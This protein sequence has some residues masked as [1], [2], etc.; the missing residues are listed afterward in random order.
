[1]QMHTD[2]QITT[3]EA[4]RILRVDTSTVNRISSGTAP[5]LQP[6]DKFPGRTGPKRFKR[7]DVEALAAE[8]RAEVEAHLARLNGAES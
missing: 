2:E 5:K 4:A 3:A 8:R 7:G 1:M 6:I